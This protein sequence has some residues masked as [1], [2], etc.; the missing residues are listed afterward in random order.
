[1][2]CYQIFLIMQLSGI[3]RKGKTPIP[4][5]LKKGGRGDFKINALIP[6]LAA[7]SLYFRQVLKS[8]N[9]KGAKTQQSGS[10]RL[11]YPFNL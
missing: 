2:E 3:S 6:M 8:G 1:M 9:D 4:P 5:P 11:Q 7:G 10:S